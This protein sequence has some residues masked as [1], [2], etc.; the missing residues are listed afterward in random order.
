MARHLPQVLGELQRGAR[1]GDVKPR[2]AAL[3][4]ATA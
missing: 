4:Q 1:T 3:R 2:P